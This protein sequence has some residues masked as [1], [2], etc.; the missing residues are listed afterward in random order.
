[1]TDYRFRSTWVIDAPREVLFDALRDYERW[2]EWWPGAEAMRELEPT[3]DDGLGGLG[4]YV[5]RS[6]VGYRLRF[7]GS[8]TA[9]QRPELLAGSV[10]G[11]L[12]GSGTWRLFVGADGATVLVYLWQVEANRAWLRVIAPLLRRVLEWNHDRLMRDGA[13]GLAAHVGA[14]LV[15]VE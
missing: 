5:W 10:D 15:S 3:G 1:M 2:P 14:R 12:R 7:D 13:R 4:R 9:V 11:D 8:A 6:H